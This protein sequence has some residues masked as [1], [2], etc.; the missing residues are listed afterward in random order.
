[1]STKSLEW[2]TKEL[3][4]LKVEP[5]HLR[6]LV[7]FY[8]NNERLNAAIVRSEHSYGTKEFDNAVTLMTQNALYETINSVREFY[9]TREKKEPRIIGVPP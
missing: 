1:M 9:K 7:R 3:D 2:I 8:D 4:G 6:T 5:E